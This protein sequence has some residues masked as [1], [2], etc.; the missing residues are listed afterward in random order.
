MWLQDGANLPMMHHE[1]GIYLVIGDYSY[2]KG[3]LDINENEFMFHLYTIYGEKFNR[4]W[5]YLKDWSKFIPKISHL[6][7]DANQEDRNELRRL[8]DISTWL[9]RLI[10]QRAGNL[11]PVVVGSGYYCY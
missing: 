2:V 1:D 11:E 7:T 4:T 8:F 6:L 10:Q 3:L 5:F 9:Q